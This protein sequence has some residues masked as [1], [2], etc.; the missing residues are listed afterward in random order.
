VSA[1]RPD[2]GGAAGL[3]LLGVDVDAEIQKLCARSFRSPHHYPVEIVRSALARGARR[4]TVE[5][6][7]R[8]LVVDDDGAGLDHAGQEA[9][10]VVLD[11]GRDEEARQEALRKL[12]SPKRFGIL[13][14]LAPSPSRVVLDT[15]GD[16]DGA[17]V[18]VTRGQEVT[19]RRAGRTHGT[20]VAVRRRGSPRLEREILAE[21]CRYAR[22]EIW[23]D[24]VL[25]SRKQASGGALAQDALPQHG[26]VQGGWVA[27]PREGDLCRIWQLAHGVRRHQW[28]L[29]PVKGLVFEVVVECQD[30]LPDDFLARAYASAQRLY[31]E[32]TANH[33]RLD[34]SSRRRVEELC[35]L[36]YR[37]AGDESLLRGFAPFQVVGAGGGLQ[38]DELHAMARNGPLLALHREEDPAR[39][40][41]GVGPVLSLDRAQW[42]FLVDQAG[43]ALVPPLPRPRRRSSLERLL[44]WL[45]RRF[46]PARALRARAAIKPVAAAALDPAERSILI[47]VEEA[48]SDARFELP[49]TAPTGIRQAVMCQQRRRRPAI[50]GKPR[51]NDQPVLALSRH[52]PQVLQAVRAYASE[53]RN[54]YLILPAL[55]G[56][57]DGWAA[58]ERRA[59]VGD[60]QRE[61][62]S[63]RPA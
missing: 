29:R 56:G 24:G 22:A 35:F 45:R 12:E 17:Q 51:G 3:E 62:A 50:V 6:G 36:G 37:L 54:L 31:A 27:V 21:L 59:V 16:G 18:V 8:Q 40:Q 47:A 26:P 49:A 9:L 42:D 14:A 25:V 28:A 1:P 4:V 55:L 52:H 57:H 38:L 32:L 10:A 44:S 5:V 34:P 60:P 33:A 2:D 61:P 46:S 48:L 43:L 11:R 63:G 39:Y 58:E 41:L 19:L 53:P 13:A 7:R 15:A 20:R 30:D 23:V